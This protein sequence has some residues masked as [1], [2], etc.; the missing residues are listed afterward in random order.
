MGGRKT[1]ALW[2]MGKPK[3]KCATF[4]TKR[5]AYSVCKEKN[6]AMKRPY[7]ATCLSKPESKVKVFMIPTNEELMIAEDTEAIVGALKK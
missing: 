4:L 7:S 5:S 2:M 3:S 1:G 6:N